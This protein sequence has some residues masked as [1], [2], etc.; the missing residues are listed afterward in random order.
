MKILVDADACPVKEI[1]ESIAARHALEVIMVSNLNHCIQSQYSEVVVVDGASQAADIAII[2]MVHPGDI[3]ITQDYGLA[4]MALA[5][6]SY[7][8]DPMG[9]IYTG[10]NIDRLL[11]SRFLNQKA[12]RAGERTKGP[13]KRARPDDN[14]FAGS[15]EQLILEN[16]H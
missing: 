10:E 16:I 13:R 7:A 12:R 8:L 3:V 6:G 14:R 5:K 1:I 11:L 15:L 4:S 2:N 9:K